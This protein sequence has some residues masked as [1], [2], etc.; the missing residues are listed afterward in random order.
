MK[1]RIIRIGLDENSFS[2]HLE[3]DIKTNVKNCRDWDNL[4]EIINPKVLTISG[5]TQW[6]PYTDHRQGGQMQDSIRSELNR[7]KKLFIP[8][9]AILKILDI[10]D[11]W[12]L[13]DLHAGTKAQTAIIEKVKAK[14]GGRQIDYDWCCGML[15]QYNMYEDRGYK[16]GHGWLCEVLPQEVIKLI[17]ELFSIE[18]PLWD[19]YSHRNKTTV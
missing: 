16:Y 18:T 15:R 17:N 1:E 4:S 11:K 12:H 9:P 7:Y 19:C 3:L 14:Q 5:F 2:V 10:W 13:N 8:K 6:R